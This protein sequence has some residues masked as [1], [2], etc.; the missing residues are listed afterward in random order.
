MK[1][2]NNNPYSLQSMVNHFTHDGFGN[3]LSTNDQEVTMDINS[4]I[5]HIDGLKYHIES[6]RGNLAQQA[7]GK[8]I[9]NRKQGKTVEVTLE[10]AK[11]RKLMRALVE[12]VQLSK[13]WSKLD[14]G[15]YLYESDKFGFSISWDTSTIHLQIASDEA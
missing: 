8:F 5:V 6:N 2:S 11:H 9:R 3:K 7:I 4:T 13:W 1:L 12:H 15:V 14:T 10:V